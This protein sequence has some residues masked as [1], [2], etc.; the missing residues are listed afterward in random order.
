MKMIRP[1]LR[2]AG[3]CLFLSTVSCVAASM[4]S[5][6]TSPPP[7]GTYGSTSGTTSPTLIMGYTSVNIVTPAI[8]N[9]TSSAGACCASQ[10]M[11]ASGVQDDGPNGSVCTGTMPF[12]DGRSS[13]TPMPCLKCGES[14]GSGGPVS[15]TSPNA[16][17]GCS[18]CGGA[19]PSGGTG[20]NGATD[21]APARAFRPDDRAIASSFGPGMF[22]VYDSRVYLYPVLQRQKGV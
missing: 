3:V 21:F 18:S 10:G 22:S 2:R 11:V 20:V 16:G 17:G 9:T 15:L 8:A 4:V 5:A 7:T 12:S 13:T 6:Q 14:F 1:S 19:M